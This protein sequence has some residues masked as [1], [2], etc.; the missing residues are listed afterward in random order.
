MVLQR[1][2]HVGMINDA[3]A[4]RSPRRRCTSGLRALWREPV[5]WVDMECR[6]RNG[7]GREEG[8]MVDALASTAEEGRGHAAKRS[9]EALAA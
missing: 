9:G 5:R 4:S 8:R 1:G 7:H 6:Q 2:A 3:D